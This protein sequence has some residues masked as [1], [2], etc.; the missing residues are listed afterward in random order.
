MRIRT[1]KPE[2]FTHP[3]ILACS[4][5]ARYL[6]I[7]LLGQADDEGR[8]YDQ[9]IKIRGEAFGESD[10]VKVPKLL[11]ELVHRGR[12]RRYEADG[13]RC[14]QI[15]NFTEHQRV[16]RPSLSRIPR[17]PLDESSA[18]PRRPLVEPSSTPRRAVAESLDE[19][20]R[21]SRARADRNREQGTGNREQGS[22]PLAR[23][24]AERKADELFESLAE[25]CGIDWHHLTPA[26]RGELNAA[27]KALREA[28]DA[29]PNE[30]GLR[31]GF[32]RLTY[33]TA[34]LTPS[35]LAKHWPALANGARRSGPATPAERALALAARQDAERRQSTDGAPPSD[36]D[37]GLSAGRLPSA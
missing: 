20:S 35:A 14:I 16:D 30:I 8:L 1:I 3:S 34:A 32:Y 19:P 31:A 28:G 26:A 17:E 7:A 37:R 24:R 18:N 23:D 15:V 36:R 12:I 27:T 29:T 6:L 11:E 25:A 22:K 10:Q 2:F 33:P 4:P 21:A 5:M 13:R 9:P